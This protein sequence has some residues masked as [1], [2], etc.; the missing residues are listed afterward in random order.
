MDPTVSW[1]TTTTKCTLISDKQ[2]FPHNNLSHLL[3]RIIALI[4]PTNQNHRTH[5]LLR[6]LIL[7][8]DYTVTTLGLHLT[9]FFIS[10][11]TVTLRG[12]MDFRSSKIYGD[13]L[14]KIF[15]DFRWKHWTWVSGSYLWC[16]TLLNILEHCRHIFCQCGLCTVFKDIQHKMDLL[17]SFTMFIL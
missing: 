8:C 1:E 5:W 12:L 16:L 17:N 9:I 10:N 6:M 7:D 14:M 11:S 15:F 4:M 3:S 2:N 13:S